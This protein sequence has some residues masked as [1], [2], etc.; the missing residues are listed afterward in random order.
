[1]TCWSIPTR[2]RSKQVNLRSTVRS[3]FRLALLLALTART[4]FAGAPP[5]LQI[6]LRDWKAVGLQ[7]P[8]DENL[9]P[10]P[11]HPLTFIDNSTLAVSFPVFNPNAKLTT[12]DHPVGGSILLRIRVVEIPTGQVTTERTWASVY[13]PHEIAALSGGRTLVRVGNNFGIYSRDWQLQQQYHLGTA[14][15]DKR[16]QRLW[17]SPS[18]ETVFV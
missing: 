10:G 11:D 3:H 5:L 1:M 7:V 16:T 9:K 8:E 14:A 17:V 6:D 2:R 15:R 12:R 13:L 18:G 4:A